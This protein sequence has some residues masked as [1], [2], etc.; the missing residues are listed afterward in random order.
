VQVQH[1]PKDPLHAPG[2]GV[3]FVGGCGW[4]CG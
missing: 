1:G 2:L 3:L 4:G